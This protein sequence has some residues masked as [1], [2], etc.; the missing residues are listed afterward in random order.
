M[1]PRD[2]ELATLAAA[3]ALN[4]SYCALAHGEKL[5]GLG[6][7]ERQVRDV[8][9]N[10]G[11]AAIDE[12]ERAIVSYAAKVARSASSVTEA[13][14]ERL[15]A[16]GLDDAQV[17]DIAATAAAR[18]FFSKLLDSI[19]TLPDSIYSDLPGGLADDLVVGR[20]IDGSN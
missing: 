13:D 18:C 14:V 7:D 15:R 20:P 8:A 11:M 3:V 1:T 17:F 2:Y 6:S 9:V 12:R 19:G 10:L 5:L 16:A 4:S